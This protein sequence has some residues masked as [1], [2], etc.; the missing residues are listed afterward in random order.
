MITIDEVQIGLI[1]Y[2]KSKTTLTTLLTTSEHI[3]ETQWQG[4]EFTYPAVR[5]GNDILP[6]I[7][8][9]SPDT[10]EGVVYCL[11]E[12]KSSKQCSTIAAEVSR[13]LHRVS[14]T[15]S[16]GV[17]F[18]RIWVTRV[19]YPTQTEETTIWQSQVQ[20]KAQVS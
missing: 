11:S 17:K 19:T 12:Q 18:I 9:C 6:S 8:G 2:L 16:N 7:D 5:T 4:T 1:E 13:L 15:S 10:V 20:I 14:F 3:K